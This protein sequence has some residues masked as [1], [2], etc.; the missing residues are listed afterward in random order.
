MKKFLTVLLALSVVFTYTVGSA[1][2]ADTKT[3]YVDDYVT[4]LNAERDAQLG[5]LESDFNQIING[6][7]Y[8]D[9]GY[10]ND[11]AKAA[12]QGTAEYVLNQLKNSMDSKIRDIVNTIPASG[13][14]VAPLNI[15]T[16]K[17]Q[18]MKRKKAI[19]VGKQKL[20]VKLCQQMFL[21]QMDSK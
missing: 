12:Y 19:L 5:Y 1:F 14:T 4:A 18:F 10:F 16:F 9:D 21:T 13:T 15:M 2:A 17:L 20:S 11:Y 3:Y 6:F 7:T 8:D